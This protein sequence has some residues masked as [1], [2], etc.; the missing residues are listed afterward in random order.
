MQWKTPTPAF[1]RIFE[2]TSKYEGG[3]K[4]TNV[5]G[6]LGGPTKWGIALNTFVLPQ[7]KSDPS[8]KSWFDKNKDGRVDAQDIKLLTRNDAILL[9]YNFFWAPMHLDE[10]AQDD[11]REAFLIFDAA[12]NHGRGGACRIVQR[13]LYNLGL[14][15]SSEIDGLWGPRTRKAVVEA[16]YEDFIREFQKARTKYYHDIVA[17]NESQRKFLRGW[18][19]RVAMTERDMH[20]L[21]A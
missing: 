21:L 20:T 11:I 9:Y 14:I 18:L 3:E 17:R 16:D 5:P 7:I 13:A 19:N 12:L 8:L 4:Y 10:I 6:D 2:L 15:R 1:E